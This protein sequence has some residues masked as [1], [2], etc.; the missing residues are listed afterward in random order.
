MT[1]LVVDVDDFRAVNERV[2]QLEA[3]V[4]LR[5]IATHVEGVLPPGGLCCRIGGDEFAVILPGATVTDAEATFARLRAAVERGLIEPGG[6]LALSAG[7][8]QWCAGDDP[9]TV[10]E[11][12]KQALRHAKHASAGGAVVMTGYAEAAPAR[13]LSRSSESPMR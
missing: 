8:T 3:D 5:A 6:R 1:L 11:R 2:G 13:G 12:A 4:V 10:F 9:L 7:I